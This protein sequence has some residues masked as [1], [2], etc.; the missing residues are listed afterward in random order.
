MNKDIINTT[1]IERARLDW[2]ANHLGS[3]LRSGGSEGHIVDVR[4]IGGHRFTTC[5]LLRTAG[6]RSG[7]LRIAP[8]IYGD[9]GGEVVVVASKG[10]ADVHPAWYL[11]LKSRT[12]VDFQVATQAFRAHWREPA[13]G[14]REEL[15]SF[16]ENIYPPY[17]AY[18]SST[19]RVIPLVI[20]S[21]SDSIEMFKPTQ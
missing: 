7:Q 17:K 15:W 6:R 3:Y 11:N 16:M 4:E 9:I 18:Q 20:L 19:R 8:L 21:P 12:T 13:S 5:L 2:T 14:E 10:G 1:E